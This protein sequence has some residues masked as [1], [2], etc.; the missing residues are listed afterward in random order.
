MW[1]FKIIKIKCF[2]P[3]RILDEHWCIY[4]CLQNSAQRELVS[5]CTQSS[6]PQLTFLSLE[7]WFHLLK[8]FLYRDVHRELIRQFCKGVPLF[9][10][11]IFLVIKSLILA[12][13]S[14]V[15]KSPWNKKS[16]KIQ[17][18]HFNIYFLRLFPGSSMI[19]FTFYENAFD[20]TR[21][22]KTFFL[23]IHFL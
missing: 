14:P 10:E 12:L 22:P 7:L 8:Y 1:I 5:I 21:F 19:L 2:Y 17:S 4:S 16:L 11:K 3:P 18:Y 13:K 20:L 9:S 6:V 15:E 23:R